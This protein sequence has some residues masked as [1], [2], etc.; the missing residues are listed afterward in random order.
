MLL[1]FV[2]IAAGRSSV[3][4]KPSHGGGSSGGSFYPPRPRSATFIADINYANQHRHARRL[5]NFVLVGGQNAAGAN[6]RSSTRNCFVIK[7]HFPPAWSTYSGS[8]FMKTT[9]SV[10]YRLSC[11]AF[12]SGPDGA[13]WLVQHQARLENTVTNLPYH[14]VVANCAKVQFFRLRSP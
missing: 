13:S 12:G 14:S 9:K 8:P 4:A 7:M 10:Y 11:P 5:R 3:C 6:V 2:I 1:R